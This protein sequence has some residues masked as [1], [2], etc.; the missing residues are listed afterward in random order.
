MKEWPD[1]KSIWR[2]LMLLFAGLLIQPLAYGAQSNAVPI[3]LYHRLGPVVADSMTIRTS[4]FASQL[5]YLHEHG[6]TVIPLRRLTDYLTDKTSPPPAKSVVITADDGHQSIY[7][8][9]FPLIVKYHIPVTLFIYPSAISNAGYALTWAQLS[10]M[11]ASGLVDIQSHTYWHPNFKH[12]KAHLDATAYE[13]L[14]DSQLQKSKAALQRKT[15]K[16]I[17]MLAWPYGIFDDELINHA[18]LSGYIAG[19]T[20]ERRPAARG[21]K[22][23]ALPRYLITDQVQ[24]EKLLATP[25]S[26]HNLGKP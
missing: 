25:A 5:Q 21:D 2:A 4:T 8:D 1:M 10:E 17:D 23:L 15:G 19:F 22:L 26:E 12:E 13:K 7:T 16:N 18:R 20:L 14:V 11:Q 3:L 24:F 9:L 6:Y